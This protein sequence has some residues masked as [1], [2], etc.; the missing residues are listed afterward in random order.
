MRSSRPWPSSP[1]S[2]VWLFGIG[3]ARTE[4]TLKIARMERAT[5]IRILKVVKVEGEDQESWL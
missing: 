1:S 5:E 4:A 2:P 3:A